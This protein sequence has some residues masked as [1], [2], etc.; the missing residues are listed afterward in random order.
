MSVIVRC[1]KALAE[2]MRATPK[3]LLPDTDFV[4]FVDKSTKDALMH[5]TGEMIRINVEQSPSAKRLLAAGYT[6]VVCFDGAL[7]V[8][9]DDSDPRLGTAAATRFD[10]GGHPADP[11]TIL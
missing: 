5:P 8:T 6:D 9:V 10:R 7:A 4:I 1:R 3:K 11:R 2:A